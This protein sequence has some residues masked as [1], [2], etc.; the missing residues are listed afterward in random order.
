MNTFAQ[1]IGYLALTAIVLIYAVFSG[2]FVSMKFYNWFIKESF[3]S[4][5]HISFMAFVGINLFLTSIVPKT[6][7]NIKKEFKAPIDSIAFTAALIPW[8]LLLVGWMFK[9]LFF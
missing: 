1:G 8:G 4:L 6:S 5:P 7:V 9:I 3:D 2:A